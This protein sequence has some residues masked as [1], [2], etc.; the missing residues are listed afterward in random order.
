MLRRNRF[1]NFVLSKDERLQKLSV[2]GYH[3]RQPKTRCHSFLRINKFNDTADRRSSGRNKTRGIRAHAL[4]PWFLNLLF[5]RQQRTIIA[6]KTEKEKRKKKTRR[7]SKNLARAIVTLECMRTT[8]RHKF[9]F[10][11][12]NKHI[13]YIINVDDL[14]DSRKKRPKNRLN[15]LK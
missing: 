8:C 7:K 15:I 11:G 14:F 1:F 5:P 9:F 10:V 4:V 2:Y 13:V 12:K 6:T 3:D